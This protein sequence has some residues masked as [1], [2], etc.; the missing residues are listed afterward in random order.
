MSLRFSRRRS[1]RGLFGKIPLRLALAFAMALLVAGCPDERWDPKPV[2]ASR[3]AIRFDHAD[4]DPESAEY[5]FDRDPRT[6][7]SAP[8]PSPH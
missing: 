4:F 3:S 7:S 8:M 1:A 6:G 5:A 2:E